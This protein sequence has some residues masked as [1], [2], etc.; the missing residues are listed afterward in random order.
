ML[1]SGC[2]IR[3]ELQMLCFLCGQEIT[4]LRS[5]VDR[6][7]CCVEHRQ[8]ARLASA[9]VLRE[10]DDGD[11]IWSVERKSQKKNYTQQIANSN[12]ASVVAFLTL[13]ALLVA[14]LMLPGG[15]APGGAAFP[16]ASPSL[17]KKQGLFASA[18]SAVGE[19]VRGSAPVTL[20]HDF[21]TGT[22][23]WTT[24]ALNSTGKVDDPRDWKT[25]PSP[26]SVV[27]GTL[28][29][30]NR[31]KNLHNYQ[32][33]FQGEIEKRSL[34]W[35]FRANDQ[36]NYYGAKLSITRPG[37]QPNAGLIRYTVID[38][39]EWDRVQL[40]L[41]VTLERGTNYRVRLSVHDDRFVTYLNGQMVGAWT[42]KRL[43]RGGVGFFAEGGDD[44]SV[45]WVN[46]SE[47]DSFVGRMLANFGLF[48]PPS[49]AFE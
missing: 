20:R 2:W 28:R 7:Y 12:Q 6:Q 15:S 18:A 4:W 10:E 19:F 29:L 9:Q 32:M 37:P 48:L 27:A 30:W 1:E 8:E 46:L 38:G 11:E 36:F 23:D 44:Q 24:V 34:S 3:S 25:P 26:T 33:E 17:A 45:A 49:A 21:R 16:S 43:T 47:R 31:S 5:L 40:P 14:M 22:R 35:A 42:D 41:P 39:Q 13:A